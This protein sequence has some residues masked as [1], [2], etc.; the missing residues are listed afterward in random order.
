M[1]NKKISII[2]P[3]YNQGKYIEDTVESVLNQ[4]YKN[5]EIIVIN[6]N[7]TDNSLDYINKIIKNNDK[8]KFINLE[9][10]GGVSH[11]RN[12]A[13]ENSTGEYI[14]PLDAD[15]KIDATYIE[16]AERILSANS[17]IGIVYPRVEYF[18]AKNGEME[19]DNF[20]N[21]SFLFQNCIISSAL[22]MRKDWE[23]AGKYDEKLNVLEDHDL[24]LSFIVLGL[25]PYKIDEVLY[26]YRK[27]DRSTI[28]KA[29][30][31]ILLYKKQLLE[32]HI[33]LFSNHNE[34]IKRVFTP[35]QIDYVKNLKKKYR[36]YRK[37]LII[38][39]ILNFLSIC[40][41]LKSFIIGGL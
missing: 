12:V 5:I 37:Y 2:I 28:D 15:D 32:K 33:K 35:D 19:T 9:Q 26:F 39:I 29:I 22:F 41:L 4:T 6:D 16:K 36:K 11:A 8:I 1:N 38:S 24:W 21:E 13:I 14:L 18:G 7:S 25:Q 20:N 30:D 17:N 31:N 27:H 34:V 23:L 10:N 40:F 3:C